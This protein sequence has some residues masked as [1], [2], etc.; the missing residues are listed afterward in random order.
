M[1]WAW[2]GTKQSRRCKNCVLMSWSDARD[3]SEWVERSVKYSA[4]PPSVRA[5]VGRNTFLNLCNIRSG[6]WRSS[7][8]SSLT[9]TNISNVYNYTLG[10]PKRNIFCAG[11]INAFCIYVHI[12]NC[13]LQVPNPYRF[14][15]ANFTLNTIIHPNT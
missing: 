14:W 15:P 1:F 11:W 12:I 13:S 3:G 9:K 6:L 2:R 4:T 5:H 7:I 10:F 8:K